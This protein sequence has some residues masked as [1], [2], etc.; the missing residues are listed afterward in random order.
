MKFSRERAAEIIKQANEM[1]KS[2]AKR[3][4]IQKQ[5]GVSKTWLRWHLV[6]AGRLRELRASPEMLEKAR[7]L[8]AKDIRW[9]IIERQ[10][11]VNWLTLAHAIYKQNRI[12]REL[13]Q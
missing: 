3:T 13:N 10:L 7:D 2:G 1:L 12:D 11:G 8:R 9:K 4:D 6:S 5:F